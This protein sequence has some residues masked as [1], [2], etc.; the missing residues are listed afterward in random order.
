VRWLILEAPSIYRIIYSKVSQ[1]AGNS[2]NCLILLVGAARFELA[3]PCA[4]GI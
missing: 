1:T 4:Q 3:T 2:R